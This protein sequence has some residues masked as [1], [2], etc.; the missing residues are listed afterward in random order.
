MY[1]LLFAD[2]EFRKAPFQITKG[3]L[4]QTAQ[5]SS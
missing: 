5:V 1:S 2:S 4:N 3:Y